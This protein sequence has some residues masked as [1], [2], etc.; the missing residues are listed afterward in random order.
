VYK[1]RTVE[2]VSPTAVFWPSTISCWCSCCLFV[3][4][5]WKRGMCGME[6]EPRDF[7]RMGI[8]S[9]ISWGRKRK[10]R[11]SKGVTEWGR[12]VKIEALSSWLSPCVHYWL[13]AAL[14]GCTCGLSSQSH[15][16][17]AGTSPHS[18]PHSLMTG[19]H[20]LLCP[21]PIQSAAGAAADC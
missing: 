5:K 14:C 20:R 12:E 9:A 8:A 10:E 1:G 21:G 3:P 4:I 7:H 15:G 18:P 19:S 17:S 6:Q 11:S 13:S 16:D 2:R